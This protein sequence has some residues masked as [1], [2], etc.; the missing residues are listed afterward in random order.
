MTKPSLFM[1]R[2]LAGTF[3]TGLLVGSPFSTY[4]TYAQDAG[5]DAP[6]NADVQ[7]A[8]DKIVGRVDAINK[9][10][11]EGRAL[12]RA[13]RTALEAALGDSPDTYAAALN[14]GAIAAAGGGTWVGA[15]FTFWT[16]NLVEGYDDA[17]TD[18]AALAA[19]PGTMPAIQGALDQARGNSGQ[20]VDSG[21]RG[22]AYNQAGD[23]PPPPTLPRGTGTA[24]EEAGEAP[25]AAAAAAA[26][27]GTP[28][29]RT[30]AIPGT[31]TSDPIS[32]RVPI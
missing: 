1:I 18:S 29:F 8:V 17:I 16:L 25:A 4:S 3:A 32:I 22:T 30:I 13:Y 12:F 31:S 15:A 6:S 14:A 24:I 26:G 23:S 19:G 28:Q 5:A 2:C 21:A 20:V 27:E 10:G 9:S 11:L 7:A